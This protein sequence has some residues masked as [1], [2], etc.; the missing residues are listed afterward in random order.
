[1]TPSHVR[2]GHIAV[3]GDSV[4]RKNRS[5]K[6]AA[7]G[8]GLFIILLLACGGQTGNS[9]NN[10]QPTQQKEVSGVKR[11]GQTGITQPEGQRQPYVLNEVL[12]KFKPGVDGTAIER[13]RAAL[14]LEII[15]K[16][17][18]PNL[19]LM[20]ITDGS[21]VE[22]VIE[23]LKTVEAVKYAEPNYVVQTTQ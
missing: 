19:Y 15:R 21:S 6:N 23:Q 12:V 16:F 7:V 14:N 17:S 11:I 22:A 8:V 1:M 10:N 2:P 18:S 13:I 5:R 4:A 3:E 20:K 9:S